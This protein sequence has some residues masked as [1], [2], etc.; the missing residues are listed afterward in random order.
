MGGFFIW[1]HMAKIYR[2]NDKIEESKTTTRLIKSLDYLLDILKHSRSGDALECIL[3]DMDTSNIEHYNDNLKSIIKVNLNGYVAYKYISKIDNSRCIISRS[4][5]KMIKLKKK[6]LFR[7]YYN[8]AVTMLNNIGFKSKDISIVFN[9]I[10]ISERLNSYL[11]SFLSR[12]ESGGLI[13][14]NDRT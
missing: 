2:L 9:G 13:V 4:K 7:L 10:I 6:R 14:S 3:R 11:K 8:T 1:R 12:K 5:L